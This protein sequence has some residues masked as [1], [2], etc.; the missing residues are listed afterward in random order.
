MKAVRNSCRFEGSSA[1]YMMIC[2]LRVTPPKPAIITLVV[3]VCWVGGL[4]GVKVGRHNE[5]NNV[6]HGLA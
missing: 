3:K 4:C 6:I 2:N 5:R 1:T